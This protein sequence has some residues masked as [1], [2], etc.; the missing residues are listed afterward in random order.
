MQQHQT[1]TLRLLMVVLI[2]LE[3]VIEGIQAKNLLGDL[4]SLEHQVTVSWKLGSIG[5]LSWS[6]DGRSLV[7][8]FNGHHRTTTHIIELLL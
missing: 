3:A 1:V 5:L 8:W 4:I 7:H 2:L 6:L